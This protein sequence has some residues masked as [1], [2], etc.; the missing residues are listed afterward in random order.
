MRDMCAFKSLYRLH[1]FE[2]RVAEP[3]HCSLSS[4]TILRRKSEVMHKSIILKMKQDELG[5]GI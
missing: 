5:V 2:W 4:P 1:F 3:E